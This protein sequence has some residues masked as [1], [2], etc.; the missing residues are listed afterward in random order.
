MMDTAAHEQLQMGNRLPCFHE[1]CCLLA[2]MRRSRDTAWLLPRP[3]KILLYLD[4][5]GIPTHPFLSDT[6]F[7]KL[8]HYPQYLSLLSQKKP[9]PRHFL[10][11]S[12]WLP[13]G[14][15]SS[16]TAPPTAFSP[17]LPPTLPKLPHSRTSTEATGKTSAG[18][19][20]HKPP[21]QTLGRVSQ[22]H[23][24]EG[25]PGLQSKLKASLG[26]LMSLSQKLK[27]AHS[28]EHTHTLWV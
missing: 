19:E 9:G 7:P 5:T 16:A 2:F 6:T 23:R 8:L 18:L 26:N 28:L 10:K 3:F 1:H 24:V 15:R 17:H 25:L 14:S 4:I 11:M 21:S 22:R 12:L 27:H 20:A 13:T